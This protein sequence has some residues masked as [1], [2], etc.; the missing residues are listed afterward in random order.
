[1]STY[2]VAPFTAIEDSREVEDL[3]IR[4]GDMVTFKSDFV[5]MANPN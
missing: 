1:M 3:G 4:V 2:A 5:Q